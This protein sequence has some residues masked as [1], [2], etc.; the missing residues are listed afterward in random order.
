MKNNHLV[1]G[2][3]VKVD[4]YSNKAIIKLRSHDHSVKAIGL[5]EG[6]V[7]DVAIEIGLPAFSDIDT[8]LMYINAKRQEEYFEYIASL[9]PRRVIF[10]PGTENFEF[11]QYLESRGIESV[12][13][14]SLV[15]LASGQY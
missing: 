14:C 13:A 15:L 6:I 1:I 2:A 12:I 5:R 8:V 11:V 4:R 7:K 10:N 3:S 9:K